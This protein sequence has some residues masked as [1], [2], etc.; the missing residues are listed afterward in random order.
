MAAALTF[1]AAC[2]A[3]TAARAQAPGTRLNA[4]TAPAA[5][6]AI[7]VDG[8][9]PDERAVDRAIIAL[10]PRGVGALPESAAI[11]VE[12]LGET[13]RVDV[14]SD[15]V[16]RGRLFRDASRD[17]EQRARFA[18]VFIVLTLLP[19]EL[20]FAVQAP[21]L[22][23]PPPPVAVTPPPPPPPARRLR[24]EA[25]V[26]AEGAPAVAASA[27][28]LALGGELRAAYRFGLVAATLGVGFEPRISFSI[29]GL[30]G[31]ELRVPVDAG[32]RIQR[33]AGAVE[34]AG[35]LSIVAAPLHAQG[36]N[37][38]MPTS[39]TRLD[40]GA[41]AGALLRFAGPRTRLAPF[42]GLHAVVFP[43]PYEIS[44]TPAG[45]LGTTPVLWLGATAGLSA[46]L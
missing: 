23:P 45:G 3:A 8:T 21:P 13:Y 10:I 14:K 24:L 28:M 27:S 19:P 40:V 25:G 38:A 12:D 44:A 34:L 16:A 30:D 35:E 43:W 1:T 36:L 29:G 22:P 33:A 5:V 20:A 15:S 17:C 26:L 42:L 37:T 4:A 32:V 39:G 11:S 41:R 31:H 7:S 6:A 2:L 46:S 18:A 9:C